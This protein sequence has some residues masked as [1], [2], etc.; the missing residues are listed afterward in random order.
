MECA[1]AVAEPAGGWWLKVLTH[2]SRRWNTPVCGDRHDAVTWSFEPR[3]HAV[4]AAREI[5]EALLRE[6]EMQ[7]LSGDVAVVVSELVTNAVRHGGPLPLTRQS[8][9]G[10]QLSLMRSGSEFI[11]AVRDGGDRL[12]RR[13]EA[14]LTMEGGRGLALVSAFA[15]EWG[16]I[17]TSPGGKFVWA[18]FA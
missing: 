17:P 10:I 15:R 4:G 18:Q 9:G 1:E 6:W 8:E 11:C 5:S 13:R 7:Y 14:D 16:V 3:P 2:G 12:P